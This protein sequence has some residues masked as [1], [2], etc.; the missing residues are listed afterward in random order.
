MICHGGYNDCRLWRRRGVAEIMTLLRRL[1][2]SAYVI[3]VSLVH[4]RALLLR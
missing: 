2:M 4:A 3:D 1:L